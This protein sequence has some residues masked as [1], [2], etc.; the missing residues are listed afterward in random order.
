MSLPDASPRL[1]DIDWRWALPR[2]ALVFIVT[3]LLVLAVAV[4]VETTQP[5]PPDGV[6][7]D[8]RP[9]LGSLAAWDGTYYLGIAE[10][11]YHADPGAFPDYAFYPLYPVA[12]KIASLFT[13]GDVGMAAIIVTNLAF[14]AALVVLYALS[15]RFLP[16]ERSILSLWFLALAP[17]AIAFSLTYSESMFLLF[18]VS[19]F[20][21]AETRRPWLV[22]LLYALAV[23]TRA[24]GILLGL[25]LL[26]LYLQQDGLRPTRKWWPLALGPLAL[27][28]F[29]GYLW[30]LTGDPLASINAQAY[31]DLPAAT[32][33]GPDVIDAAAPVATPPATGT[34]ATAG[35]EGEATLGI[36]TAPSAV[37]WF[38]IGTLVF[39]TFLFVYFRADRV[40][41]PYVLL[42]VLAIVSI[43]LSGRLQSAPRYLAVAWP[44]DWV[45]ASRRSRVGRGVV[46]ALFAVT[47]VI[48]LWLAFTWELAP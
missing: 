23:L 26:V 20:L 43:F 9:I 13:L 14:A 35:A 6:R 7:V 27:A 29:A 36:T 21:A 34:E 42:A 1:R 38:W 31:W 11:G 48:A 45:L 47:H 2:I 33:T 37:L 25:P 40:R 32:S 5:A 4:A 39:Y 16:P 18:S 8:E 28:L 24:P 15:V 17:G 22:G 30:W 12:T 3:R 10:E 41:L 46:L 19:A 44:F